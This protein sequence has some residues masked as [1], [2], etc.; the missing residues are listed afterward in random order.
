MKTLVIAVH[1]IRTKRSDPSWPWYFQTWAMDQD[2]R[3]VVYPFHYHAGA[4]P[5]W[6]TLVLN[7]R[8]AKAIAARVKL[9]HD[10]VEGDKRVAFISHSNGADVVRLSILRLAKLGIRTKGACLIAGAIK[11]DIDESKLRGMVADGHLDRAC[12]WYSEND[13]VV[14]NLDWLP[15]GNYGALGA[16]GFHSNN[17][18]V[19][20]W[21]DED[22]T[23]PSPFGFSSRHF[24]GYRHSDYF[25][26]RRIFQT[27]ETATADMGLDT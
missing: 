22:E 20:M 4:L 18:K 15:A 14:R 8:L 19:G 25:E 5:F 21:L 23:N 7:R 17:N 6:N 24:P 13:K 11:S 16:K 2:K 26:E 9:F 10:H 12:A 27:F 3:F 1:G